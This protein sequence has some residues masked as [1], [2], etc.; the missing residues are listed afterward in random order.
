MHELLGLSRS[1]WYY[2][3]REETSENLAVMRRI[4]AEYLGT[5]FY[6][7]RRMAVTLGVNRKR[8]QRRVRTMGIGERV[9]MSRRTTRPQTGHKIYPYLL[10][11]VEIRYPDHV[12]STDITYIPLR[13]GFLYLVAIIDWFSRHVLSW[14]HT[15][16]RST[17]ASAW[18]RWTTL[19]P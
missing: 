6:G 8:V 11:N 16:A 4:D 3:T 12:W 2:Q 1:T 19:S 10:R 17:G 5:P 13:Q 15:N 14:R 7:S 9:K 18:K